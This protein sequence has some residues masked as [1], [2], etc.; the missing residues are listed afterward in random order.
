MGCI[1]QAPLQGVY[2]ANWDIVVS[3]MN[4]YIG[5]GV[6][7]RDGNGF[8]SAAKS[9]TVFAIYE[10]AAREVLAARQTAKFC[11]ELGLFDIILEGDSLMVT[12]ALE[13]KGEN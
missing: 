5:V 1:W 11:R 9:T 8:V 12:W 13:G 10:P 2:K 7:V 6:V 4:Q 3:S